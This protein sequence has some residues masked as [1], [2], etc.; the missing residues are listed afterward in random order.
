MILNAE[1]I[2]F[3]SVEW[4]SAWVKI[5]GGE[6]ALVPQIKQEDYHTLYRWKRSKNA[7]VKSS[8]S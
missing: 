5:N 3:T 4:M 1:I 6:F 7:R 8:I 2:A